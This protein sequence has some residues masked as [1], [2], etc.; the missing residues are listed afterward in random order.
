MICL[1]HYVYDV[2][3][4]F[5]K[6]DVQVNV[7]IHMQSTHTHTEHRNDM[8]EDELILI[9]IV[10]RPVGTILHFK[11]QARPSKMYNCRSLCL[12]L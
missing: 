2:L 3:C 7:C 1:I 11:S 12:A 8:T 9:Y 4:V 10:A 6:L 5:S